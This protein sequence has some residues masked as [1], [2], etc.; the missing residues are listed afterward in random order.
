[1]VTLLVN[2]L[3]KLFS[4]ALISWIFPRHILSDWIP[5]ARAGQ[6]IAGTNLLAAE[7]CT[8]IVSVWSYPTDGDPAY[9][10]VQVSLK[11]LIMLVQFASIVRF[12]ASGGSISAHTV[13]CA[14]RLSSCFHCGSARGR[15]SASI[16]VCSPARHGMV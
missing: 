2:W 10:L 1:M 5:P 4:M 14:T 7:R 15:V 13:Q 16:L 9:T 3:V 6:Y 8:A 12:L 11:D